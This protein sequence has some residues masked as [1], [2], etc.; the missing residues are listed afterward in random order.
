MVNRDKMLLL[1]SYK[2][3]RM[4]MK[5]CYTEFMVVATTANERA[6]ARRLNQSEWSHIIVGLGGVRPYG[7]GPVEK[8]KH[9]IRF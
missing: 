6:A 2:V 3:T 4:K 7:K 9:E 8:Y 1:S 5:L